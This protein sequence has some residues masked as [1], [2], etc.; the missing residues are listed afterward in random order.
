MRWKTI[1]KELWSLLDDI[2]TAEDMF[3]P[4]DSESY[5]AF[6]D[7]VHKKQQRRWW[8]L[9]S[10]GHKLHKAAYELLDWPNASFE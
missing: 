4:F 3:S 8:Y 10:D 2:D 6:C 5:K 9:D 7:C 1:A